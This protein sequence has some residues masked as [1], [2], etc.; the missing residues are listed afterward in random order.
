MKL[1]QFFKVNNVKKNYRKNAKISLSPLA[2]LVIVIGVIL[3]LYYLD[4]FSYSPL[5][6]NIIGPDSSEYFDWARRILHG[7]YLYDE[8]DIHAPGYPYFLALLMKCTNSHIYTMRCIQLFLG[9]LSLIVL[10]FNLERYLGRFERMR[11]VSISYLIFGMCYVPLFFYQ[12][13]FL[14]ESLLLIIMPLILSCLINSNFFRHCSVGKSRF[15]LI[16]GA[17]LCGLAVIVH[18]LALAFV[19]LLGIKFLFSNTVQFIKRRKFKFKFLLKSYSQTILYG[20]F[21]LLI[22]LPVAAYNTKLEGHFVPV[23]KNSGY[24][25]YLGNNPKATGGCYIWPGPDWEKVHGEAEYQAKK[26]SVTKNDIFIQRTV[27]FVKEQPILWLEKLGKKALY[28][29]NYYG[30]SAGADLYYLRFYTPIAEKTK[31]LFAIIGILGLFGVFFSLVKCRSRFTRVFSDSLLI[32]IA[33]WIALTLTVTGERYRLMMIIPLFVVSAAAFNMLYV[34]YRSSLQISLIQLC[35]L[36]VAVAMVV[37]PKVPKDLNLE[38]GQT[39]SIFGEAYMNMGKLADAKEEFSE[40]VKL[41][42]KWARNYNALGDISAREG[43][44]KGAEKAFLTALSIDKHNGFAYLNLGNIYELN[45]Q[46]A[47]AYKYYQKAL[48]FTFEN[49]DK[50]K[51]CYNL[52]LLEIKAKKIK[53]AVEHLA[54]AYKFKNYDVKIVNAYGVALI[55]DKQYKEAL[56]VLNRALVNYPDNI[57]LLNSL[58]Y[59]HKKLGNEELLKEFIGKIKNAVKKN[60]EKK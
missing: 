43:D 11:F 1:S 38:K 24:N 31:W 29:W 8:V 13:A 4:Q 2:L 12:S 45:N 10:Y 23:Q 19:G 59:I 27:K 36:L 57:K 20:V 54:I 52:G 49:E 21:S 9:M 32:V 47:K 58:V 53:K 56:K 34:K 42:P 50:A 46:Y 17:I 7:Q 51:V 37:M 35:L 33:T 30:M 16:F 6:D 3:R 55:Y 40:A 41:L 25:L 26:Q 5:F 28:T 18:P 44:F 60:K 22:I 48:S 14:S 39:A 15:Y